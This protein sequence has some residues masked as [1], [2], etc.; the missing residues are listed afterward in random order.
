MIKQ[1][2]YDMETTLLKG[3]FFSLGKQIIRHN[4][5]VNETKFSRYGIICLSYAWGVDG[6]VHTIDWDYEKQD[7]KII[8]KVFNKL[9]KEADVIIGKN[10]TRFDNKHLNTQ[11]MWHG[12]LDCAWMKKIDDLESQMRKYFYMPSYSLDYFSNQLG[13]GG[14]DKMEF[15]DWINI[16]EKDPK[17]GLKS[18]NR[19]K[20]YNA[21][22]VKDTQKIWKYALKQFSPRTNCSAFFQ[23][24]CCRY[25][26]SSNIIKNGTGCSSLSIHQRWYC[27]ACDR[28]AGSTPIPPR[29]NSILR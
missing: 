16:I 15:Q 6:K 17:N 11:N 29:P 22:D 26:G 19:M 14:K 25:C 12:L 5:L 23:A 8:L 10:S 1:L 9:L 20:K 21:K 18:F 28:D 27:K 3:Y 7:T 4:Q 13:L 24:S 2:F